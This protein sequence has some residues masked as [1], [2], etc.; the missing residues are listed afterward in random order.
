MCHF[1]PSDKSLAHSFILSTSLLTLVLCFLISLI[2]SWLR[3]ALCPARVLRRASFQLQFPLLTAWFFSMYPNPI[4]NGIWLELP[5]LLS[6]ISL[7]LSFFL[8]HLFI[9]GHLEAHCSADFWLYLYHLTSLSPISC[10]L[11]GRFLC[12]TKQDHLALPILKAPFVF[13]KFSFY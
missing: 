4:R 13:S 8:M 9:L 3:F 10:G 12:G 7:D 1:F 6:R 5:L 11:G 2:S